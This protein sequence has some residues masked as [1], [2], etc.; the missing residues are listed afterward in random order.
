V[1][2]TPVSSVTCTNCS[3]L[4]NNVVLAV[5]LEDGKYALIHT[6]H[7]LYTSGRQAADLARNDR[8]VSGQFIGYKGQTG[9]A[10][11]THLHVEV[12]N[13]TTAA[14]TAECA[15]HWRP[16]CIGSRRTTPATGSVQVE[17]P[18]P[19]LTTAKKALIPYLS[20][21]SQTPSFDNYQVFGV[22]SSPL[23]ASI[24]IRP[25]Q[26]VTMTNVGVG[27]RLYTNDVANYDL[28]NFS[29]ASFGAAETRTFRGS[30]SGLQAGDYKFFAYINTTQR[31]YPLKVTILPN[32]E[33]RIID[34]ESLVGYSADSASAEDTAGYFL[35]GALFRGGNV[36]N[37]AEWRPGLSSGEYE[38]Y[39][40]VPAKA[41]AQSVSYTISPDGSS[42]LTSTAISHAGNEDRWVRLSAG[43]RSTFAMTPTGY[44]QL[45]NSIVRA[46][47]AAQRVG[48]DAVKFVYIGGQPSGTPSVTSFA[49]NGGA[50]NTSSQTVRLD[51]QTSGSPTQYMASES[52]SFTGAAWQSYS[53]SPSFT[54][55]LSAGVHTVYF[56]VRNSSGNES[57]AASDAIN[58]SPTSSGSDAASFVQDVTIPDDTVMSPGQGFQKV[59]RF[60]NTGSTT[61]GNGYSLVFTRGAQLSTQSSVSIP[62]TTP[63]SSADIGVAMTAPSTPG[64][65]QSY[66]RLRNPSGQL[67]GPEVWVRI[68]VEGT[69]P[70][71]MASFT[72]SGNGASAGQGQT[73]S[74]LVS[75]GGNVRMR[76]DG[77]ASRAGS[78]SITDYIWT[79]NGTEIG[80]GPVIEYTFG[81]GRHDIRLTVRDSAGQTA[82]ASGTVIVREIR[83]TG[84]SPSSPRAGT[85][86]QDI[87]VFGEELQNV[88]RIHVNF[89]GGGGG[90][91]H[92]PG[93]VFRQSY[94]SLVMRI[95]LGGRGTW[96]IQAVS[97][98][99]QVSNILIFTV[100]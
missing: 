90:T 7:M 65:Y 2:V 26:A 79:S 25:P 81:H 24:T 57:A 11:G 76:F 98:G 92:A 19:Y 45:S 70:S 37:Y 72:M 96:A 22:A 4:G 75:Y 1:A 86:D 82:N 40:H 77:S 85:S 89:P 47:P 95:T 83:L 35:T 6:G 30:R 94:N 18:S 5:L 52:A 74:Y 55:G 78:G 88:T 43:G 46:T 20:T 33:S 64:T 49:I 3:G 38:I 91:L 61:W 71:P 84:M 42:L 27:G 58:F 99:G 63:G 56:K 54:L 87:T 59:W 8:V 12:S 48:A 97:S 28:F 50:A 17:N 80:R 60:N 93:Q 62:A 21:T 73:L 31:G 69:T 10:Q 100:N 13:T 41:S 29:S 66:W 68:R 51:N 39:V 44:V 53:S 16:A 36:T 14:S 23:Y 15:S 32:R 67:F 34:N 9:A